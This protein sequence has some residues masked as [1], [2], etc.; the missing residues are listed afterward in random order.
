MAQLKKVKQKFEDP[1]DPA[2]KGKDNTTGLAR[3]LHVNEVISWVRGAAD[4][5]YADNAAAKTAG[6]VKGDLYHT[7][8]LLKIVID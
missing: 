5:E 8:G 6:L 2:Y 7:A 4:L 1:E 3:L